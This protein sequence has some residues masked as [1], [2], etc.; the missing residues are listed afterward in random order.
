MPGHVRH[1]ECSRV[2]PCAGISGWISVTSIQTHDAFRLETSRRLP[3]SVSHDSADLRTARVT[4]SEAQVGRNEMGQ[5]R[6][7]LSDRPLLGSLLARSPWSLTLRVPSEER[8]HI[9]FDRKVT[10][11]SGHCRPHAL[12]VSARHPWNSGRSK[13]GAAGLDRLGLRYFGLRMP[14]GGSGGVWR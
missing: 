2:P 12:P 6:D 7:S 11:S 1:I 13:K 9:R 3:T 10:Y 5:T 8:A 4:A 14:G